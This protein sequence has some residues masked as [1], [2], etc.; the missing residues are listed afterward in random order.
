MMIIDTHAHAGVN[1]F[2]PVETIL[3]PD[4]CQR[5]PEDGPDS[6][7][8]G[9]TTTGTCWKCVRRFPNRFGAV[10][11]VDVD[12]PNAPDTLERLAQNEEV[13]G[14]RLTPYP[15]LSRAG[16]AGDLAQGRRARPARQLLR[17]AARRTLPRRN[18]RPSWN[19]YPT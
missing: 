19:S 14:M 13:I 1:W 16:P 7:T 8:P 12:D 17:H 4:E 2:E 18:F 6:A 5:G 9:I 10:I 3:H 11:W 15:A